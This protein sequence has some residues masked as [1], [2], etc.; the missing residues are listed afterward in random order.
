VAQTSIGLSGYWA[1]ASATACSSFF[2]TA[3]K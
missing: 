2:S 1:L 3:A